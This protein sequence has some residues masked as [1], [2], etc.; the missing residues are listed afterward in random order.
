MSLRGPKSC[1]MCEPSSAVDRKV[2][3]FFPFYRPAT[4]LRVG[5]FD[6]VARIARWDVEYEM[7]MRALI[8]RDEGDSD[9]GLGGQESYW[10]RIVGDVHL[11]S[12]AH[13]HARLIVGYRVGET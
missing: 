4:V 6:G 12:V 7:P 13:M 1:S 10:F 11:R 3:D 5:E 9:G 2:F 8:V